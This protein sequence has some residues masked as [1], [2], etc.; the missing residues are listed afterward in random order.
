[1][2]RFNLHNAEFRYDDEDP[3]GYRSGVAEIGKALGASELNTSAYELPPGQALCAYHYEYVE[4]WL[5]VLDGNPMLR[6]P[7]GEEQLEPGDVVVFPPGPDGAHNVINRGSDTARVLM[8]SSARVPAV[9][10]YPDS[11]KIAVFTEARRDDIRAF[12][13][14]GDAGYWE[15]ERL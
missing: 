5:V 15:R 13:E 6:L 3:D 12:R 1:M 8:F 14:N 7:E 10:V 11:D 2:R 9:A 4:E